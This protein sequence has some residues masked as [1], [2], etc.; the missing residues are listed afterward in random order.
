LHLHRRA[1]TGRPSGARWAHAGQLALL[2]YSLSVYRLLRTL[3][4]RHART[5]YRKLSSVYQF[6]DALTDSGFLGNHHADRVAQPSLID[7]QGHS[8]RSRPS[9]TTEL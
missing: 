6:F 8:R 3:S 2:T 7:A 1:H 5:I 9:V 4:F